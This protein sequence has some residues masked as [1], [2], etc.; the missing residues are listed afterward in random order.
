MT[1]AEYRAVAHRLAHNFARKR[2]RAGED[3][4]S[5]RLAMRRALEHLRALRA[6]SADLDQTMR[7]GVEDALAGKPIDRLRAAPG[8]TRSGARLSTPARM[9]WAR[10][11]AVAAELGRL[12]RISQ[13]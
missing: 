11:R 5:V 9:L 4:D 3:P 2:L 13:I 1:P 12:P 10:C 6:D 7:R 8:S